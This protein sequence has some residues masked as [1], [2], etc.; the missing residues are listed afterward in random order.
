MAESG[1]DRLPESVGFRGVGEMG[2]RQGVEES[3]GLVLIRGRRK[4]DPGRAFNARPGDWMCPS[5]NN[6]NFA[7]RTAC[8][9]CSTPKPDLGL[10]QG[11]WN[12]GGAGSALL[13]L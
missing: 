5:C 8:F 4:D 12:A 2:G 3:L 7:S 13:D 9:R 11:N 10:A 6:N 1:S